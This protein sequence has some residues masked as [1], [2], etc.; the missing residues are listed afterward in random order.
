M[1]G[2]NAVQDTQLQ[3]IAS[4]NK[5]VS[6]SCKKV[7]L[8]VQLEA[9]YNITAAASR[10]CVQAAA[11]QTQKQHGSCLQQGLPDISALRPD[12]QQEWHPDKNAVLGSIKV[13]PQSHMRVM[14]S[15]PDCP[16]GCPHVWETAV[17]SRTRGTKCPTLSLPRHQDN[18][19]I[20]TRRKMPT[21]QSRHLL[22]ADF[23]LN[24]SAKSAAMSG[25]L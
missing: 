1:L 10:L 5:I 23:G 22:A 7:R 12:L 19:N 4:S 2:C 6:V 15:C 18:S 25:K 21:H 14:W 11:R 17:Y 13:K 9:D 16:A 3:A 20:G 8:V 24:G